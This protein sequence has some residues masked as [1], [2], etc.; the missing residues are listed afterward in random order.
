[1]HERDHDHGCDHDH[2]GDHD[3]PTGA[4][5]TDHVIVIVIGG[6]DR[7]TWSWTAT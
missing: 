7:L 5:R 1:V 4:I 6:R 3:H 2:V